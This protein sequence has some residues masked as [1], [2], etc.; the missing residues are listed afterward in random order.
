MC[1]ISYSKGLEQAT[2]AEKRI[3]GLAL[4]ICTE[5]AKMARH[6]FKMKR[7]DLL[8][9]WHRFGK[10][11]SK[12]KKG[13][14]QSGFS[15]FC[16]WNIHKHAIDRSGHHPFH[17]FPQ[18]ET[19]RAESG[20]SF[21]CFYCTV[22]GSVYSRSGGAEEWK[23]IRERRGWSETG[24]EPTLTAT[25]HMT[26]SGLR[27]HNDIYDKAAEFPVTPAGHQYNPI[28]RVRSA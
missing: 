21:T 12:I 11:V 5:T 6:C 19:S 15:N 4:C 7:Y 16:I 25:I 10:L 8:Y 2:M 23:K 22:V 26:S 17:R 24:H 3:H 20:E 27:M 28:L 9:I 13:R 1:Q 14:L 18:V